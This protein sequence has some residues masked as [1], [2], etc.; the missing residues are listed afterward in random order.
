MVRGLITLAGNF[1]LNKS[2]NEPA[3]VYWLNEILCDSK[4][5]LKWPQGPQVTSEVK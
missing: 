2:L 3:A 5:P 4:W 1:T